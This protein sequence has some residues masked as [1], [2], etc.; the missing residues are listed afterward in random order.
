M[1]F[2][3]INTVSEFVCFLGALIFLYK[4]KD[5]AWRLMILFLLITCITELAGLYMRIVM[6]KAN[7][8]VYNTFLLVEG[9]F[10]G[11]FFYQLYGHYQH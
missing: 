11:Y 2:I 4:D 10:T 9:S 3:T 8:P 6:Y 5:P 1:A 7:L